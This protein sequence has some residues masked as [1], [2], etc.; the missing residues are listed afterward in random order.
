M[1]ETNV[2]NVPW[3]AAAM[4]D[5]IPEFVQVLERFPF[6]DNAGGMGPPHLFLAWF[7]TRTLKPDTIVESGVWKGAGTW[8]LEQAS[9]QSAIICLEPHLERLV[10]QSSTAEY[11]RSDFD[12][13]D[14]TSFD[15]EQTLLFFDDHQNAFG[16]IKSAY[17][18]GFRHILFEDNY[19]PGI[20]DC[21]SLK[22]IRA[23][24]GHRPF[25]Q[26]RSFRT[27]IRDRLAAKLGVNP[28]PDQVPE[29]D[30]HMKGL[31]RIVETYV[32]LP[33]VVQPE[34]TR[35]GRA[36]SEFAAPPPLFPS[37]EDAPPV[38]VETAQQYT[39]MAYLRL[40]ASRSGGVHGRRS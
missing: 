22:K 7:V 39:Y 6:G 16:R 33:P 11:H 10:Y 30:A 20:G 8:I 26:R 38:F 24:A 19:P 32:E 29:T 34:R 28:Y 3:D 31:A 17:F 4:K 5:A 2:G 14:W 35:F 13:R 21:Y 18:W 37:G 27:R 23:G 40:L 15:P 36:W 1:T 12:D 9:P 25:I